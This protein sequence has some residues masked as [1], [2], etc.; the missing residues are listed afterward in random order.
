ML[1][2][3]VES[4][5][6]KTSAVGLTTE[7]LIKSDYQNEIHESIYRDQNDQPNQMDDQI[8]DLQRQLN[9]LRQTQQE[10]HGQQRNYAATQS[11]KPRQKTANAP[12]SRRGQAQT[13]R[14]PS[15]QAKFSITYQ[16][17][18]QL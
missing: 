7:I 12:R 4:R 8:I 15:I 1:R 10:K 6:T 17:L 5:A 3:Y 2:L 11:I 16:P 14:T 18:W 13:I 9:T